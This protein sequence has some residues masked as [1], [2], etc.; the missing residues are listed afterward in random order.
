MT[1]FGWPVV[2]ELYTKNARS[3]LGS[4]LVLL[5][6]VAPD[7]FLILRK[8]LNFPDSSFS[9]PIRMILS[10]GKPTFF[11]ASRA[12]FKNGLCVTKALAPASLS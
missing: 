2:P 12:A 7:M 10:S 9:S 1:P 6:R 3:F 11:A 8:C 4:A 5:Y